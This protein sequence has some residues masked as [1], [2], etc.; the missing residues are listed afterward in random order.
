MLR[1]ISLSSGSC[2]NCYFIH[3]GGKGLLIDAGVSMRRVKRTLADHGYGLDAFSAVLVTHDHLD[4]IRHLG[5]ICK[6]LVT[7][8]YATSVLHGALARHTFTKDWIGPCRKDLLDDGPTEIMPGVSVRYFVVPHDATQTVGYVID[9]DGKR[10]VLMTDAGSV[11]PDAMAYARTAD[12][13][14]VE[15]NY[16]IGMLIGGKYTE[17]LKM[18]ICKGHGHLSNDAC[19]DAISGFWHPGLK[20]I[21]LCHLSEN[22]NTPT[23]AFESAAAALRKIP[24]ENGL[25]A[26]DI[27]NLRTLP[28]GMAS[29]MF[30]L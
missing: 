23:L 14:V 12:A 5:S 17:E 11:P 19:A 9:W 3:D 27:T 13:V 20:N 4:H 28:R 26:K 25:T 18:R 8:V 7:P 15:S 2:G 10:F 16:D 1:F 22:N 24:V 21:F 6:K 30:D 29:P